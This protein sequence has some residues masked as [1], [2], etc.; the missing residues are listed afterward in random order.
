MN[1][2]REG[3]SGEDGVAGSPTAPQIGFSTH[4]RRVGGGCLLG[5]SC[6]TALKCHLVPL[7]SLGGGGAK[8]QL[9]A[10]HAPKLSCHSEDDSLNYYASY[11]S[12]F[13]ML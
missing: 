10:L 8:A 2:C 13:T 5:S 4:I 12:R 3:Q 1:G 11:H 9:A 6:F 7:E